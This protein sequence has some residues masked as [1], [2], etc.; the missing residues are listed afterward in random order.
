MTTIYILLAIALISGSLC[1]ALYAFICLAV[2]WVGRVTTDG[3]QK[4]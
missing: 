3:E 1:G 2:R 4:S